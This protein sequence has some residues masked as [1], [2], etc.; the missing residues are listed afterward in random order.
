M[1]LFAKMK[2]GS[3]SGKKFQIFDW[4]FFGFG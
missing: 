2:L 3:F 4:L 1:F